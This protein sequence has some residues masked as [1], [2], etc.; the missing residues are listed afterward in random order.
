[1]RERGGDG[2]G[3]RERERERER[4]GGRERERGGGREGE[5]ERRR[6]GW[7]REGGR[8]HCCCLLFGVLTENA[9][10]RI[11]KTPSSGDRYFIYVLTE[12][13]RI[14]SRRESDLRDELVDGY[15]KQQSDSN[16]QSDETMQ[17]E[18]SDNGYFGSG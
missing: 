9:R 6:G 2:R 13:R 4:E 7:G 17:R 14:D 16:N 1:M 18:Q 15:G 8:Y 10:V 12:T 11:F 5:R 3:E